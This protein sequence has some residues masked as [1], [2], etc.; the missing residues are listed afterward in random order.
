VEWLL[1]YLGITTPRY[2]VY[3][4]TPRLLA[5]VFA[6]A[7]MLVPVNDCDDASLCSVASEI[8]HRTHP[9]VPSHLSLAAPPVWLHL[10]MNISPNRLY[11]HL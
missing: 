10:L 5:D 9:L 8:L 11:T 1:P 3:C 7:S 4:S 6:A 2:P